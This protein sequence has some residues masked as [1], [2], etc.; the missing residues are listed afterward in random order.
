MRAPSRASGSN[1][2]PRTAEE[3]EWSDLLLRVG[4][5]DEAA[6]RVLY[7][8]YAGQLLGWLGRWSVTD[9]GV[10]HEDLAME[11]W[12]LAIARLPTFRGSRDHFTRW[13]YRIARGQ[14]LSAAPKDVVNATFAC[15]ELPE[16]PDESDVAAHVEV[17][18]AIRRA[19]ARLPA[20]EAQVITC[21]DLHNL[22]PQAT[23]DLLGTTRASITAARGRALA[24]LRG[25]LG[26]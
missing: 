12:A 16:V 25:P 19:M 1:V 5:H 24:R 6:W 9:T 15:S 14:V 3:S 21:I 22:T 8:M 2:A 17:E 11:C 7:R 18:D 10:D 20:R 23:A 13:L 26:Q 4:Q